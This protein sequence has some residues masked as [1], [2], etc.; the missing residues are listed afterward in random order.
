MPNPV[1]TAQGVLSGAATGASVGGP[2]GGLIGGG[3]G[4]LGGLFGGDDGDEEAERQAAWL[5]PYWDR[6]LSGGM[7]PEY[8]DPVGP[9]GLSPMDQLGFA[10][11]RGES[12]QIAKGREGALRSDAAARGGGTSTGGMDMALRA[13]AG[14]EAAGRANMGDLGV[15]ANAQ[16][17]RIENANAMNKF[18]QQN[19][20][21]Y[22]Q[23]LNGAAGQADRGTNMGLYHGEKDAQNWQQLMNLGTQAGNTFRHAGDMSNEGNQYQDHSSW[24]DTNANRDN[25]F[26][27]EADYT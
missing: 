13:M 7:T 24:Y 17:R 6:V 14:Q 20:Q 15:A 25:P 2:V 21:N 23:A 16:S 18:N 10:R 9:G 4:L 11:A 22:L 27:G 19:Y 12:E 3:L 1:R 5:R 26:G 8:I